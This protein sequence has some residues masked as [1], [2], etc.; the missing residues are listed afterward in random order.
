MK[1]ATIIGPY[2]IH[3]F[4]DD[5]IG[6]IISKALEI[7]NYSISIPFFTD[8]NS[9]WLNVN[10]KPD[11]VSAVKKSDLIIIGGGGMFGDAGI[12]PKDTY[13]ILSL[14]AAIQGKLRGKRVISTGV[15]AGPLTF[16]K[17]YLLT[18]LIC[19]LSERIGVRDI[20]SYRFLIKIGVS[21][22]KIVTGADV[23]LLCSDF[24]PI[25]NSGT[26][27]GIQF[28][29]FH[30][31]DILENP[32][33]KDIFNEIITFGHFNKENIALISNGN[34]LSQ[35]CKYLEDAETICYYGHL[36]HFLQQLNN[37]KVIFTSHLHLAITAYSYRIPCFSLYVR[38]KT[39][40]FYDQ[41]G[42]P[43]RAVD[44]RSAKKEDCIRIINELQTAEWTSFD[45][46]RLNELKQKSQ[47]LLDII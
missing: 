38:E 12:S 30:F 40:R 28:D 14:K 34:H 13:R 16:K 4:G 21:K 44:L 27:I 47:T 23:A 7:K 18:F 35:L 15:G 1:N 10:N 26:K 29:I 17:S 43:E 8:Q 41:I 11:R 25:G 45:E 2:L 19:L 24:L 31:K 32:A 33:I 5:L 36:P 39:R 9:K 42:H 20:E 46:E 37:M 6:A 3:N 22:R